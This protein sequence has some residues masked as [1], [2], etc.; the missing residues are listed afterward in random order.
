MFWGPELILFFKKSCS[1]KENSSFMSFS[2]QPNYNYFRI[3][4]ILV[5]LEPLLHVTTGCLLAQAA[6]A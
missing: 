6:E 5:S 2:P 3:Y 4:I 1:P